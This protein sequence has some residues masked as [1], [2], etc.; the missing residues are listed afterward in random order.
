MRFHVGVVWLVLASFFCTGAFAAQK[1][2]M[3][4]VGERLFSGAMSK[5]NIA[6]VQEDYRIQRGDAVIVHIWGGTEFDG[7]LNVDAKGNLYIPMVGPVQVSGLPIRELNRVLKNRIRSTFRDNVGIYAT[8]NTSSEIPVYVT[9]YVKKPGVYL[10]LQ[11]NSVFHFID[12]A[13]GIDK[14]LGSFVDIVLKRNGRVHAR[15]NAYDFL[16]EG[17]IN[18]SRFR[19]GDVIVVGARR[20][21]AYLQGDV[22]NPGRVEFSQ[23]APLLD[24]LDLVQPSDAVTDVTIERLSGSETRRVAY[25]RSEFSK[26]M[27]SPGDVVTLE[28]FRQP[29]NYQITVSGRALGENVYLFSEKPPLKAIINQLEFYP[30]SDPQALQLFRVAAKAQ[31]KQWLNHT[32]DNL[33]SRLLSNSSQTLEEAKIKKEEAALLR[34]WIQKARESEPHGRVILNSLEGSKDMRLEN[35]DRLYIPSRPGYVSVFGDVINPSNIRFE[36]GRSADFYVSVAGGPNRVKF[37]T[38][39]TKRNGRTI[40]ITK[41]ANVLIEDGDVIFVA[42]KIGTKSLQIAKEI[43]QVLYHIAASVAVISKL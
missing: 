3:R 4:V 1:P 27:L 2:E 18:P 5:N 34:E 17:I 25:Q 32:L 38:F 40:N 39:V 13:G 36:A 9:G 31:Q 6:S 23:Q 14:T 26:A 43:A 16:R 41:R 29:D 8:L 22:A 20:D 11:S 24:F 21:V 12:K 30:D 7:T 42:P 10:G 28:S 15:Y 33:E 37:V 35:G 19:T